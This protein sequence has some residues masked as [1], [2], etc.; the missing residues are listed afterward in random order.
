MTK[1]LTKIFQQYCGSYFS[2]VK[3]S[4]GLAKSVQEQKV[5]PDKTVEFFNNPLSHRQEIYRTY[6]PNMKGKFLEHTHF[7]PKDKGISLLG[8]VI[9]NCVFFFQRKFYQQLHTAKMDSPISKA[10]ANIYMECFEEIALG[11]ECLLPTSWWKRYVDNVFNIVKKAQV[12]TPS[13]T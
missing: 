7:I 1:F 6:K 9:K 12:G 2:F 11:P 4:K 3:D 10:I 5:S 13:T 8:L